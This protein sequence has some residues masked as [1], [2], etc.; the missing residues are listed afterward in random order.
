MSFASL[1]IPKLAAEGLVVHEDTNEA[2][3]LKALW[4]CTPLL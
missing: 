4:F 2:T 1:L 3:P